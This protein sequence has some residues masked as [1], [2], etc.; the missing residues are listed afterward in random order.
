MQNIVTNAVSIKPGQTLF[1]I[2]LQEY[3]SFA[4]ISL[5]LED[6]RGVFTDITNIPAGTPLFIRDPLPSLEE[7]N[8]QV[9]KHFQT[10]NQLPATDIL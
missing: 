2:A 9:V 1:D 10:S 7:I 3:G 8:K 5:L 6:N 4:A